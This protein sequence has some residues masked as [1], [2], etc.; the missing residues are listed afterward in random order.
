MES[1]GRLMA[2]RPRPDRSG[3]DPRRCTMD[4]WT[5]K[6]IARRSRCSAARSW[7]GA[8]CPAVRSRDRPAA[9]DADRAARDTRHRAPWRLSLPE[10]R[11]GRR[12]DDEDGDAD[13]RAPVQADLARLC[14]ALNRAGA[15]Y[16]LIGGFALI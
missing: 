12:V 3:W 2:S 8:A 15:R 9:G 16:V 4:P 7:A 10:L 5:A 14:E 11:G 13:A 6:G 1:H